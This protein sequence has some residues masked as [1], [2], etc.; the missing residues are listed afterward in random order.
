M[1]LFDEAGAGQVA[2]LILGALR[3]VSDGKLRTE[4]IQILFTQGAKQVLFDIDG[5]IR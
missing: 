3:L 2:T 1:P 5:L 4:S